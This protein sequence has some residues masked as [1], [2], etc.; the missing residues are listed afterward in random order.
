MVPAAGQGNWWDYFGDKG[1]NQVVSRVLDRNQDLRAAAARIEA[2]EAQVRIASASQLPSW[3][4][5]STWGAGAR[6]FGISDSRCGREGFEPDFLQRR[7][8]S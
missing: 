8:I 4:P 1:L 3:M 5:A 6:I 2:A 7:S